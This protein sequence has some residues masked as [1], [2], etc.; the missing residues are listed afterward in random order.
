MV[1][2]LIPA[3]LLVGTAYGQ[4]QPQQPPVRNIPKTLYYIAGHIISGGQQL[5]Y[6][7]EAAKDPVAAFTRWAKNEDKADDGHQ[8][9]RLMLCVSLVTSR[10]SLAKEEEFMQQLIVAYQK[11]KQNPCDEDKHM[12][13]S[14]FTQTQA[15]M[16]EADKMIIIL[17]LK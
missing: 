14:L 6:I 1:R 2:Y 10:I 13:Q 17:T 9:Q 16:I 3:I 8:H 5:L 4:Q 15:K 12:S 7:R 11:A